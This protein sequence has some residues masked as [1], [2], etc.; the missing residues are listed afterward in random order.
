[1]TGMILLKRE[2]AIP[3]KIQTTYLISVGYGELVKRYQLKVIRH[4]PT[5]FISPTGRGSDMLIIAKRLLFYHNDMYAQ[6]KGCIVA[7][8][9]CD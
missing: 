4:D 5:T 1:M 6:F 9:I 8:R 3:M 7:I 2:L